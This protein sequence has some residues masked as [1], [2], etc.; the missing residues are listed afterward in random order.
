MVDD[1]VDDLRLPLIEAFG[2]TAEDAVIRGSSSFNS[3]EVVSL[4]LLV[5]V[6]LLISPCTVNSESR[7]I[8]LAP[9]LPSPVMTG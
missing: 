8:N 1:D 3:G 4:L 5:V 6:V 7:R 2:E 9:E